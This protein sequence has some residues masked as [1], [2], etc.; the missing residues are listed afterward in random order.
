MWDLRPLR[1]IGR[2]I[3]CG[4]WVYSWYIFKRGVVADVL[5]LEPNR[6]TRHVVNQAVEELQL[7]PIESGSWDDAVARAGREPVGI[8]VADWEAM[9]SDVDTSDSIRLAHRF[10][11]AMLRLQSVRESAQS[12]A[13]RVILTAGATSRE[14]YEQAHAAAITAGVDAFLGPEDLRLSTI[15]ESYLLRLVGE[16]PPHASSAAHVADAFELPAVH[17]RHA[18][19]GRWDASRIAKALGVPL[20]TLA[21]SLGAKYSTVHKT[22]HAEALQSSLAPFGNVLAML[23]QIYNDDQRAISAWLQTPQRQLGG[24]TPV[25]ALC[26]PGRAA[27]VEQ[28][29]AGLWMGDVG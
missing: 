28:W 12:Y 18:E 7:R 15:L 29:A 11:S 25:A 24:L 9:V 23:A 8:V 26:E 2:C 19:S 1:F 20:K 16:L 13:P 17:L 5:V 6:K 14:R 3:I 4:Y 21:Q 10:K 27:A 22:P